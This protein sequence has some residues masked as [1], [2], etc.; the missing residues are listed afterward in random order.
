[1]PPDTI[2]RFKLNLMG[3]RLVRVERNES[4]TTDHPDA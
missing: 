1:V 2:R 4:S 3:K